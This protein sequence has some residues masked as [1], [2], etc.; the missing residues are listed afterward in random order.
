MLLKHDLTTVLL[1]SRIIFNNYYKV[2]NK[3]KLYIPLILLLLIIRKKTN[4]EYSSF[5]SFK[6]KKKKKL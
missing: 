3:S 5:P 2:F 6:K 1:I 4:K